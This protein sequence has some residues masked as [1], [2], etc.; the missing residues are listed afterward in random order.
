[1]KRTYV[2]YDTFFAYSVACHWLKIKQEM[3]PSEHVRHASQHSL[4]WDAT[5]IK[6]SNVRINVR[7]VFQ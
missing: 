3:C 1:M 5:I 6:N 4:E 7:I 2:V